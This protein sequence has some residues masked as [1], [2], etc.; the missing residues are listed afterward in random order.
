[1][2][3]LATKYEQRKIVCHFK[4]SM[5]KDSSLGEQFSTIS[6]ITLNTIQSS[7]QDGIM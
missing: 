1:M 3:S 5:D 6:L 7:P 2:G 4:D